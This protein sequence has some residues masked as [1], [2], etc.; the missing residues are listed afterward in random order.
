[1]ETRSNL[2][3]KYYYIA[4]I[5]IVL[6]SFYFRAQD[7][8]KIGVSGSDTLLYWNIAKEWASGSYTYGIGCYK[9]FIRPVVFYMYSLA[10]QLFDGSDFSIK[11]LNVGLGTL[12]TL[13][14]FLIARSL[15][16]PILVAAAA[17]IVYGLDPYQIDFS[18]TELTHTLST[19]FLFLS[20]Y[21]FYKFLNTKNIIFFIL[22]AVATCFNGFTH[23]ELFT[24]SLVYCLYILFVPTFSIKKRIIYNALY[25]FTYF[26]VFWLLD[27][28]LIL[29]HATKK[30]NKSVTTVDKE[31]LFYIPEVLWNTLSN[32]GS[33]LFLILFIFCFTYKVKTSIKNKLVDAS[34][35]IP[36][37]FVT[38]AI[39]YTLS[40]YNLYI[41]VFIP[42]VTLC[43]VFIISTSYQYF[44]SQDKFAKHATTLSIS[45]GFILLITN[46]FLKSSS[47][48]FGSKLNSRIK[49][50]TRIRTFNKGLKGLIKG[51]V[52]K[53]VYKHAHDKIKAHV[54]KDSKVLVAPSI[55]YPHPGRR[56]LA[57]YFGSNTLYLIDFKE[58]LATIIH[59]NNVKYVIT[60]T[61]K[62]DSRYQDKE[63][64]CRNI[65]GKWIEDKLILG[66]PLG[67]NQSTYDPFLEK[68]LIEA[69]ISQSSENKFIKVSKDL[70]IYEVNNFE[71]LNT[72]A[73]DKI[74]EQHK[75]DN[76]PVVI[77]SNLV[78]E[79]FSNNKAVKVSFLPNTSDIGDIDAK[80]TYKISYDNRQFITEGYPKN[81]PKIRKFLYFFTKKRQPLIRRHNS[82]NNS[83]EIKVYGAPFTFDNKLN[84]FYK[85]LLVGKVELINE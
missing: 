63:T 62:L 33:P 22:C 26:I 11:A 52:P 72:E 65:D 79:H 83:Y 59:D 31:Y 32:V 5:I 60:T 19:F 77:E 46:T 85:G 67:F 2:K 8:D 68:K 78:T 49:H 16:L 54:S 75:K 38:Q 13:L 82:S 73:R 64:H 17:M 43:W 55:H 58:D 9:T 36:L 21:L 45:L 47:P 3:A 24:L 39:F 76:P 48:L 42:T 30:I 35:I 80:E 51:D 29:N 53:S 37:L 61:K 71:P 25:T 34:L 6:F 40:M 20:T 44:K 81:L 7:I 74:I 56:S 14:T 70:F 10:Y 12:T 27:G 84:L 15:K 50:F 23:E 1:M 69:S 66:A 18:R 28:L 41:R 57:P 4:V